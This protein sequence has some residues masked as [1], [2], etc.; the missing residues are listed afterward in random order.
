MAELKP[1]KLHVVFNTSVESNKLNLPRKYTL[2]HSDSTG[3]LF[4][5]ISN[6]YDLKQISKIYTRLMRDEVLAEWQKN[7]DHFELHIFLHVSG[8]FVFGWANM[9]D[10]I[11]RKHLPLVFQTIIYGDKKL[12]ESVPQL[13]ESE[14]LVH[15]QSKNKKYSKVE[16]FGKIKELNLIK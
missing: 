6:D 11:F 8:G 16:S 7:N 5:T 10:K 15:F 4:L 1:E 3:D 13:K 12:L 9:R 14:I 2:T